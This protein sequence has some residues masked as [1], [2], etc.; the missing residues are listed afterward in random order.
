MPNYF[1]TIQV[2]RDVSANWSIKNPT[3]ASGE[4]GYEL[5]TVRLKIGDG[6]TPWNFLDYFAGSGGGGEIR[7]HG[8]SSAQVSDRA[9]IGHHRKPRVLQPLQRLEFI[10]AVRIALS[11]AAAA[12]VWIVR[13]QA[14]CACRSLTMLCL[15]V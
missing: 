13:Q 11:G 5:D 8:P 15:F 9:G 14:V 7:W 6:V 10:G 4:F 2:R 1:T 3:L 12:P